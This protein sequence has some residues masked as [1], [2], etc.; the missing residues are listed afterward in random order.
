MC[1]NQRKRGSWNIEPASGRR[2]PIECVF[3]VMNFG[4]FVEEL[5]FRYTY[6]Y[7]EITL[8]QRTKPILIASALT[9]L[10][11]HISRIIAHKCSL[12]LVIFR[13]FFSPGE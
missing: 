10:V 7:S 13:K 8:N 12:F 6:A 2:K 4:V 11:L 1:Q 5:P 3:H 9:H